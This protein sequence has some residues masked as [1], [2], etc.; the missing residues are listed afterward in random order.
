MVLP[1]TRSP[2]TVVPNI[3]RVVAR[4]FFNSTPRAL[5]LADHIL[6]MSEEDVWGELQRVLRSFAR[7]HRDVS[8]I[9]RRHYA[10]VESTLLEHNKDVEN[11][12]EARRMLIGAYFTKE[13][14]IEAAAL[15]NPSCVLAPDQ[16][17]LLP[18][19][20]R[21]AMSLRATG[22]GHL[23]SLEF[24][25][26]TVDRFTGEITI[27]PPADRIEE[28]RYVRDHQYGREEFLRKLA[29][30]SDEHHPGYQLVKQLP[31]TFSY[32]DLKIRLA[33]GLHATEE[34]R[35]DQTEFREVLWLAD[36]H[37]E[38]NFSLDTDISER[39][40][41]PISEW[42]S[43]GIEDARFVRF[44]DDDGTVTYYA[45]YTA[46]DGFT[47]L[48]KLIETEDFY[49]FRIRP[50]YG[51]GASNKNLALF[52]RK[53][54]GKYMMLAR[55]DGVNNY[56]LASDSLTV[57]EEP[58]FLLGPKYSWEFVQMGNCGS[59]IETPEGWLLITHGVG[60]MRTYRMGAVLLDLDDPTKVIKRL[61]YPL[62]SPE[63]DEREG[64]VPNVVYSCG[65][66]ILGERLLIPYA[67]SD[68]AS[69]FAWTNVAE[70]LS[71]MVDEE[72]GA[73]PEPV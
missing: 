28:A 62:L 72:P 16:S 32:D 63:E 55:I 69:G 12:T 26:L 9:F 68:Y 10:F 60:P 35:L 14:S 37:H 47:I 7:R 59:P 15:F 22:E 29:N 3:K 20:V 34:P 19:E 49:R 1:V 65:S 4:F 54:N 46:Y 44:T 6:A 2:L 58:Q 48:P 27:D 21:L 45:T 67:V 36:S 41:L 5:T 70:L 51:D 50:M 64:Y 38:V 23:S 52:P 11:I 17:G 33:Q 24:R 30:M 40:I 73:K 57:W 66:L 56:I 42:E 71:E 13:F 39:V 31:E 25:Y 18:D 43:R 61:P 53:V 8:N